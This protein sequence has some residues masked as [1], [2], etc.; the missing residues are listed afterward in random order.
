MY[1][2]G[3]KVNWYRWIL[4]QRREITL[5]GSRKIEADLKSVKVF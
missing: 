4:K 1:D 2:L 3:R 5:L